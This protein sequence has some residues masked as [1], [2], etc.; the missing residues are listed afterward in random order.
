MGAGSEDVESLR[1]RRGKGS[2]ALEDGAEGLDPSGR[3][4]REVG[5]G[6][7]SDLAIKTEGL[8]EEDCGRGVAVGDGGDVHAYTIQQ[9]IK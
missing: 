5:E 4:M 1:E 7:V 6:A 9:L 2:G 3:P 8:A